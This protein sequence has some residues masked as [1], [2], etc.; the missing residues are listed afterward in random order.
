MDVPV[1]TRWLAD[2]ETLGMD[3]ARL[4]SGLATLVDGVRAELHPGAQ[5]YVSRNGRPVL[6][7]ACGEA[8]PGVAMT[9]DS[10][11]A[12]FSASKPVTAMA[13][14]ILYDRGQVGLDDPVQSYLPDFGNGKQS[15]TIRHVL[16][17]TGGFGNS[18]PEREQEKSWQEL[19]AAIC[20]YPAEYPPGSKAGYHPG[21]GWFVL[22]EIIRVADGRTVDRFVAEELFAPLGMADSWMGIPEP[23]QRELGERIA[24]VA[25]GKTE[26]RPYAGP[27]VAERQNSPAEIAAVNPGGGVRGPARDLGRF[28]EMLLAGGQ[29]EGRDLLDRRTVGL[30]TACHRWG[31]QDLTLMHAPLPWGLGFSLYGNSDLH[32][33]V[34]RRV[35]S[36]SGLVSSVA[37]ADPV[38]G[39]A[40]AIVT[41][42]LLEAMTN[43]RRLREVNGAVLESCRPHQ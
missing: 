35:F 6:E 10:L 31:M 15:C 26:R 21:S 1:E 18:F 36:H 42:G 5:V 16:T 40:C 27:E 19:I 32:R 22:G 12:W 20:A 23:R 7:F 38:P 17:H 9:P 43:A 30:F 28:Y 37:F 13:I 34:S 4:E 2:P 25:I 24:H 14:A 11:T 8:R 29:W 39:I 3:R 33:S 41:T